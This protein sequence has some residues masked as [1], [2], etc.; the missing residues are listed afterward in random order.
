MKEYLAAS[1]VIDWDTPEVAAQARQLRAGLD[2]KVSITRTLFQWV[3]DEIRHSVDHPIEPVACSASEVLRLGGGLCYAKSH[4]LAALLRAS[5]IP[6]GL[7]YQRLSV[8]GQGAPFCLHGY[9]AVYLR[10]H[11]WYRLDP[12]GNKSGIDARFALPEEK[13][14]FSATLPGEHNFAAIR[15]EPLPAVVDALRRYRGTS[16]LCRHLPDAVPDSA[17]H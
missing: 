4:L 12:R 2:D 15:A 7:C 3:R 10:A 9:N 14:A 17:F 16:E 8:D 6:A 13:L 11:G 5:G 1:A